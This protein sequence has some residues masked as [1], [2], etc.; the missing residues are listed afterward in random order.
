VLVIVAIC[1][2]EKTMSTYIQRQQ[3]A[4]STTKRRNFG[5]NQN[6][7][8][9]SVRDD[10]M[11]SEQNQE[12]SSVIVPFSVI[13]KTNEIPW[14]LP[15]D[16]VTVPAG[17]L[18]ELIKSAVARIDVDEQWYTARY[19]DILSAIEA[20][21]FPSARHHYVEFGFFEDRFPRQIKVDVD[22]YLAQYP[23]V[24]GGVEGGAIESAQWHFERYG[25]REGRLPCAGWRL[26][27]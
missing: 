20:G 14:P 8:G 15:G 3:T 22:F 7:N 27:G 23:D 4:D 12:M 9:L 25:F 17:L 6:Q 18:L 21:K 19:P 1:R 26:L 10:K 5:L 13:R 11:N 2:E 16:R 24:A